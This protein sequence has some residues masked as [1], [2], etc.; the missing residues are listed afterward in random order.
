M[1]TPPGGEGVQVPPSTAFTVLA[2]QLKDC[3]DLLHRSL[4]L[5]NDA[6]MWLSPELYKD[7]FGPAGKIADQYAGLTHRFHKHVVDS[8]ARLR[9]GYDA[10]TESARL[11]AEAEREN[12]RRLREE[13]PR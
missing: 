12:E 3:G 4:D 5:E 6:P 9:A 13:G 8:V 2:G 10:F 11:F 1:T 7:Y